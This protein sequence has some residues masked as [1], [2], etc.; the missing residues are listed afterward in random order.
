MTKE[1]VAETFHGAF[2]RKLL[3]KTLLLNFLSALIEESRSDAYLTVYKGRKIRH[4]TTL[5]QSQRE[6]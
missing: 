6:A 3:K 5:L 4:E 1:N 2:L